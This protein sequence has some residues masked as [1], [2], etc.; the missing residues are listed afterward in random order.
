MCVQKR[1]AQ[2]RSAQ[3]TYQKRKE[4]ATR[5]VTQR[6]DDLLNVL[7]DLA[8]E[9]EEVLRVASKAGALDQKDEL[10]IQMLRLRDSYSTAINQPC[11]QPDLKLLQEKDNRR[12]AEHTGRGNH[13]H[14][15]VR[16]DEEMPRSNSSANLAEADP[17][18]IDMSLVRGDGTT[19]VQSFREDIESKIMRGRSI[20]QVVAE[21]QAALRNS[22]HTPT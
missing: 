5:S 20:Y 7:S 13:R 2:V 12:R 6:C 14:S 9:V 1:R 8:S 17:S 15:H 16:N 22:D 18:N 19:L 3:R 21:R 11:A 4:S 10:G